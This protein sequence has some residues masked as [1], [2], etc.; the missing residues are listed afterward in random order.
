MY[1]KQVSICLYVQLLC[2]HFT[3]D[4]QKMSLVLTASPLQ[5][6]DKIMYL[7]SS[8]SHFVPHLNLEFPIL[9]GHKHIKLINT[10][11][12]KRLTHVVFSMILCD[13]SFSM[14]LCDNSFFRQINCMF[15]ISI[16]LD[17]I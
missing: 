4:F 13:N 11:N 3:A 8:V 10:Y 5:Y 2:P 14:T 12:R 6:I 1:Y 7:Y 17:S 16:N 9:T 15:C